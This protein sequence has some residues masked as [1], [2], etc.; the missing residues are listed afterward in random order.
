VE[1]LKSS[2]EEAAQRKAEARAKVQAARLAKSGGGAGATGGMNASASQSK[3]RSTSASTVNRNSS[4]GSLSSNANGAARQPTGRGAGGG[5]AAIRERKQVSSAPTMRRGPSVERPNSKAAIGKPSVMSA[6]TTSSI[7]TTSVIVN[8]T[9]T[10]MEAAAPA[11]GSPKM[12]TASPA[13][14]PKLPGEANNA[15]TVVPVSPSHSGYLSAPGSNSGGGGGAGSRPMS[16][17]GG[18]PG[19]SSSRPGSSS[20]PMPRGPLGAPVVS[21][22]P[23]PEKTPPPTKKKG[24]AVPVSKKDMLKSAASWR[25]TSDILKS[26]ESVQQSEA[27]RSKA[28]NTT[29]I[30]HVKGDK[31][32][33]AVATESP[34]TAEID[35]TDLGKLIRAQSKVVRAS[36][37]SKDKENKRNVVPGGGPAASS[38]S[39]IYT[40]ATEKR[41]VQP[42]GTIKGGGGA[43][44]GLVGDDSMTALL[45]AK[46][47]RLKTHFDAASTKFNVDEAEALAQSLDAAAGMG[48]PIKAKMPMSKGPLTGRALDDLQRSMDEELLQRMVQADKIDYSSENLAMDIL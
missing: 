23:I 39:N 40:D 31:P 20:R 26:L 34:E 19:S 32:E 11:L 10:E 25:P 7:T 5:L 30:T 4:S 17:Q 15:W 45:K 36:A 16:H 8:A 27:L 29:S 47:E 38:A 3:L 35:P 41:K 9:I 6:V 48:S 14:S 44:D 42:K 33:G 18:R 28:Q 13:L 2:L 1:S 24:L 43:A 46:A 21:A 22:P 37:E 12:P